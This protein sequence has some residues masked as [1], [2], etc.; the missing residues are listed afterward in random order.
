M[1]L[2]SLKFPLL[3]ATLLA[4]A[5]L[6]AYI[7][8]VQQRQSDLVEWSFRR[9]AAMSQHIDNQLALHRQSVHALARNP[10]YTLSEPERSLR[11]NV[12]Q[13][14]VGEEELAATIRIESRI[15]KSAAWFH[16]IA[17]R[18]QSDRPYF[19]ARYPVW[20]LVEPAVTLGDFDK[21]I[22]ASAA[23]RVLFQKGRSDI[24]LVDLGGIET[25]DG[26]KLDLSQLSRSTTRVQVNISGE[27]YHLLV[28]P[29]ET[30]AKEGVA[31]GGE[32]P[33]GWV[34][35]GL[36]GS[37]RLR[38]Q[39]SEISP[40]LLTF[41]VVALLL[42]A[43]S[44]PFVRLLTISGDERLRAIDGLL[45]SLCALIGI[46]TLVILL[47]DGIVYSRLSRIAD[48]QLKNLT[49][50]LRAQLEGE[51]NDALRAARYLN[52]LVLAE[53]QAA[54][55]PPWEPVHES[56]A[57]CQ[58]PKEYRFPGFFW[59]DGSGRQVLKWQAPG[60]EVPLAPI[61]PRSYF[62]NAIAERFK[63]RTVEG[64]TYSFTLEAVRGW[65]VGESFLE[66]ALPLPLS[67]GTRA[68]SSGA[69]PPSCQASG[70]LQ[71]AMTEAKLAAITTRLR[72][73]TDAV[74]P[75]GFGFA[76]VDRE[77]K[78]LF[79]SD[80]RRSLQENFLSE[81]S[82]RELRALLFAQKSGFVKVRYA[83]EP[84]RAYPVPIPDLEWSIVGY[85]ELGILQ[86][87]NVQV[88]CTALVFL[89]C[90]ASIFLLLFSVIYLAP[91]FRARWIWPSR[92]SCGTYLQ[93]AIA[94]V[95]LLLLYAL[96]LVR[97]DGVLL[98]WSGMLMPVLVIAVSYLKVH[99]E[100]LRNREADVEF[101]HLAALILAAIILIVLL[102]LVWR[103]SWSTGLGLAAGMVCTL[104]FLFW[105][106][107]IALFA[108]RSFPRYRITYLLTA[109]L[110]LVIL[111]IPPAASFFKLAWD[112]PM[113]NLVKYGQIQLLED[114][115]RQPSTPHEGRGPHSLLPVESPNAATFFRTTVRLYPRGRCESG[116]AGAVLHESWISGQVQRLL[117]MYNQGSTEMARL[118]A[119]YEPGRAWQW[120]HQINGRLV[121]HSAPNPQGNS[122]HLESILP[123]LS[124]GLTDWTG[125]GVG[126]VLLGAVAMLII[127]FIARNL[128][129]LNLS[130]PAWLERAPGRLQMAGA[131][132]ANLI[133]VS[134]ARERL[135][136]SERS[137][138]VVIDLF[139]RQEKLEAGS[140][141]D[142][143]DLAGKGVVVIDRFEHRLK[144][145]AFNEAKRRLLEDLLQDAGRRVIVLSTRDPYLCLVT[146][147]LGSIGAP[148]GEAKEQRQ[149][150]EALLSR[151]EILDLDEP[152]DPKAIET[153]LNEFETEQK[154]RVPPLWLDQIAWR[155][156]VRTC[157]RILREECGERSALQGIC[158]DML[159][160]FTDLGLDNFDPEQI[161]EEI[162]DRADSY[163]RAIWSSLSLPDRLVLV[164]LAEEGLVNAKSR[165]S[166]QRLMTRRLILNRPTPAPR[167]MNRTFRR[168]VMSGTCRSEVLQKERRSG[169]TSVWGRLR[170]PMIAALGG[171]AVFFFVTQ[172]EVF[173]SSLLFL[174]L[175]AGALPHLLELVGYFGAAKTSAEAESY[176]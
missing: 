24:S 51:L 128:L 92:D 111:A 146:G 109:W 59:I 100:R 120:E 115:S 83:G 25:L 113:E 99:W 47:L 156:H 14:L 108:N 75:P 170:K 149:K 82:S 137:D 50:Q 34:L 3:V 175:T 145:A 105:P 159:H 52:Q 67:A 176:R 167:L 4:L 62:R 16:F 138:A 130:I 110:L 36:I 38:A 157:V 172:R 112:L 165:R 140:A 26:K 106:R 117:P 66:I 54:P 114:L 6:G 101:Q 29:L 5:G 160:D 13:E 57:V 107:S 97:A 171:A 129:L 28:Q 155:L 56:P 48:S 90:Y 94:Y 123:S 152:G 135:H 91:A 53:A 143:L 78:V 164:Q 86:T 23:G 169:K 61:E 141:L 134:Q 133:Y 116:N 121:L 158:R 55:M 77:G 65:R 122:L 73:L 93:L 174:S 96:A 37:G 10:Q 150:W 81:T 44:W 15:A 43:L 27:H 31:A 40:M 76:V 46:S 154:N 21:L 89:I 88:L 49:H 41:F 58:L 70:D 17:P 161:L 87:I 74:L 162:R 173:D 125:L 60:S 163:Y 19:E 20:D 39:S 131:P 132:G 147:A 142:G 71:L 119:D 126:L 30:A 68:S 166:L 102:A 85:R 33:A 64:E 8:H 127:W 84:V 168:F 144:D 153:V 79:H 136:S 45:V 103:I 124:L 80:G 63:S 11:F 151:F 118:V 9:L 22:F 42:A 139:D 69:A 95:A 12:V 18:Q 98:F 1:R 35:C 2:P 104:V 148:P 32:T 72:P 7:L